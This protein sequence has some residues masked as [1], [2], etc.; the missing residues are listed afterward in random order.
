MDRTPA[1]TC[2]RHGTPDPGTRSS[3]HPA[4][5]APARHS[6]NPGWTG[7]NTCCATQAGG[8]TGETGPPQG[9]AP[10]PG[11]R[12][13]AAQRQFPAK[14]ARIPA[15]PRRADGPHACAHHAQPPLAHQSRV[16]AAPRDPPPTSLRGTAAIPAGRA[17]IPATPR[18]A[19]APRG[20]SVTRRGPE[21]PTHNRHGTPDPA[22]TARATPTT[23]APARHR[24]LPAL[25]TP[26]ACC[27]A[28]PRT[29]STLITG[30]PL[31]SAG[32]GSVGAAT[33]ARQRPC[34]AQQQ[35]G[36]DG[37]EYLLRHAG[38]MDRT[39]ALTTR[40]RH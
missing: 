26:T 17:R 35:S 39:P 25:R 28:L 31:P 12:T 11:Q 34:A 2:N 38:R 18:R 1:V 32:P 4:T 3:S 23:R 33:R 24:T 20:K 37:H 29:P 6:S 7:T 19:A 10:E 5:R 30:E 15:A 40:N 27:A 16:P 8:T 22:Q 13:C 14:Q 36:P 9:R 21:P